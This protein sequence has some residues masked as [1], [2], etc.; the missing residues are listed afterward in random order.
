MVEYILLVN[1]IKAEKC[2]IRVKGGV[3]RLGGLLVRI[4]LDITVLNGGVHWYKLC[5]IAVCTK[6]EAISSEGIN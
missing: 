1:L 6:Q 2:Y 3:L 4:L 5:A